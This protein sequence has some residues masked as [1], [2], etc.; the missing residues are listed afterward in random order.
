MIDARQS[1]EQLVR[2]RGDDYASLSRMLGRNTAYIQQFIRRGS[3][4]KLDEDDRRTLAHYFGVDEALLGAPERPD[5]LATAAGAQRSRAHGLTT[6]PRL[7]IGASAGPGSVVDS[8]EAMIGIAFEARW[9]RALSQS[10]DLLSMIQVAGDSMAPTLMNSDDILVDRG[11]GA[12]R[13][14]DG[15]YVLRFD[16]VLMVKRL[17]VNPAARLL[18]IR[19]DNPAYPD[20]EECDPESITV[21]GRVVWVGRKV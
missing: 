8:E 19:S 3:P 17:A 1:L 5:T 20:W 4:R 7:A 12:D 15:I 6:V 10:P 21:I 16:D 13:A 2:E 14:R 9:L 18:S 11:D